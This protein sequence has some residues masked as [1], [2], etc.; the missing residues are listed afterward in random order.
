MGGA[1]T[2]V[3]GARPPWSPRSDGTAA[4]TKNEVSKFAVWLALLRVYQ[5]TL[6]LN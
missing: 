1:Q 4:S 2:V 6:Q 5:V 3:R